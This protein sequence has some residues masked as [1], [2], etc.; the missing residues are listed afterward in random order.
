MCPGRQR[1]ANHGG[2]ASIRATLQRAEGAQGQV[3]FDVTD[4][5]NACVSSGF[6][7]DVGCAQAIRAGDLAQGAAFSK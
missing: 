5:E 1:L 3:A 4:E 2:A 7:L 6:K